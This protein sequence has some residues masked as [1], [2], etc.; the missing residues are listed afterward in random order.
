[1]SEVDNNIEG[2]KVNAEEFVRTVQICGYGTKKGAKKYVE[3][4]PKED[5]STDDL[6]V[7]HEGSM[8][9]KVILFTIIIVAETPIGAAIKRDFVKLPTA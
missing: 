2:E 5:Y 9:W 7:L 8:H 4:N 3:L 6:I 1:M